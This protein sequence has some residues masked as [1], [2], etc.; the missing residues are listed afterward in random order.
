MLS[1]FLAGGVGLLCVAVLLFLAA[2]VGGVVL[3]MLALGVLLA[4]FCAFH[5]VVWGWWLGDVIRGE[6]AAEEK[7]EEELAEKRRSGNKR[8]EA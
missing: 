4:A 7:A 5:Y 6:V 1:I 8:L 3:S 2:P